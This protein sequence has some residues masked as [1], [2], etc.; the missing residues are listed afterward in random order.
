MLA[1]RTPNEVRLADG[2]AMGARETARLP[3]EIIKCDRS[4]DVEWNAFVEA[5]P[6][7]SFY[8]RA[9][10]RDIN[11]RELGHRTCYLAARAGG[12]LVGVFPIVQVKSRLFGNIACSMPFVNYGGPA[13]VD[14]ATES[15]LL[16]VAATVAD[17]WNV[18][19]LEIRSN[20]QLGDQYQC[21]SHKVSMTVELD[22]DPDKVFN[23]FKSDHRKDIRRAYKNGY[24]ARFGTFELFDEFFDIL[25]ESWRD[26]GTP[27]Y[28]KSYLRSVV[29]T[30]P[31][32]TRIGIVYAGDGTPAACAFMGHQAGTVEGMWL[33]TRA[34]Y[35]RQLVGYVLYWELIKDACVQGHRRFHLGRSTADSGSEQFKRKWN[36]SPTQLYWHYLLRGRSA[37]PQ[38]NV[39][40]RKYHLAMAT[41][42]RLPVHVTQRI[43]PFIARC[44]P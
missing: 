34:Q 27:I 44:I 3:L 5:C 36:A 17:D 20:R 38:L 15:A 22:P 25:C 43:G 32:S 19:F 14:D 21:S 40:N 35:R 11:E 13:G 4:H 33:G 23:A 18:D 1:F 30:F 42:R 2:T 24:T 29:T 31:T 39:T 37:M 10:W 6:R 28:S 41:W 26:L 9:E 8:H 16:E 12:R 7:A